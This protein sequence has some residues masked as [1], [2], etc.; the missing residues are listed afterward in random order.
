MAL[1][2]IAD[3]ANDC[4]EAFGKYL[5][6]PYPGTEKDV[7]R[8]H[9]N[10]EKWASLLSVGQT[11]LLSLDRILETN[12]TTRKRL[13]DLLL[14]IARHLRQ[15]YETTV[16]SQE[17]RAFAE[18]KWVSDNAYSDGYSSSSVKSFNTV[19]TQMGHINP[20]KAMKLYM[21][22]LYD[23]LTLLRAT[24]PEVRYLAPHHQGVDD[25]GLFADHLVMYKFPS[26]AQCLKE[27]LVVTMILRRRRL[28]H[29]SSWRRRAQAAAPLKLPYP[30]KTPE[31]P[32]PA[33]IAD[34]STR[35]AVQVSTVVSTAV[36]VV[37]EIPQPTPSLPKISETGTFTCP[38]CYRILRP[39]R[40]SKWREHL[41]KDLEPFVCLHEG[42]PRPLEVFG[43]YKL[44]KSHMQMH[45][46]R[47]YCDAPSHGAVEIGFKSPTD[48][49]EH[50]RTEHEGTV[51]EEQLSLFSRNSARPSSDL[52]PCCIL[53]SMSLDTTLPFG[54]IDTWE[55]HYTNHLLSL[56]LP[57]AYVDQEGGAW[58]SSGSFSGDSGLSLS[59]QDMILADED[60]EPLMFDEPVPE[61][62][63]Q[64]TN[65]E[66]S[67]TA[68]DDEWGFIRSRLAS[69]S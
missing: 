8:L 63:V 5:E 32:P 16:R 46:L 13:V 53:C 47:W 1:D 69:R 2:S 27:R 57:C 60:H 39:M 15:A 7:T 34:A 25:F 45:D 55:S 29:L 28:M 6:Q 65:T 14:L 24:I 59:T 52:P 30:P 43:D 9:S 42:C 37:S 67:P 51:P 26:V 41:I 50:L 66:A 3:A 48:F 31:S 20:L 18:R 44:W 35:F 21:K 58:S 64:D 33:I 68:D 38:Y 62:E 61:I 36:S 12:T 10:F 56:A 54:V 4:R 17:S 40:P 49:E 23:F 19:V 22:R 11:G